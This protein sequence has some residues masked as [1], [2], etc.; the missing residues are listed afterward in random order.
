MSSYRATARATVRPDNAPPPRS[1]GGGFGG[2]GGGKGP[3][4][5]GRGYGRSG[6][7]PRWGRIIG[8]LAV[9]VVVLAG[10]ALLGAWAYA[11]SFDDDLKRTDA[12]AGLT[13]GRPRKTVD[14]ALNI[15]VLGTDSRDP[16]A[17]VDDNGQWRTDT[18]M[19]VHVPANHEKAYLISLPRDLYV[20][21]PKSPD[22][23]HGGRKAKLNAAFA[24]GG[25]P[26]M[27]QTVETYSGVRIDHV[28]LVDFWGFAA[29]TDAL[30]GVDLYIEK[31]I[32]SV[33]NGR[34]FKQG[35][36][37]LGGHEAL[38]YIRQRKQFPDGD[39]ARMRHQQQFLMALMKKA[40]DTG[41]L[42]SPSKLDAFLKAVT[43]AVT[44]DHDFSVVDMAL[45]FR[46]LRSDDLTFLTTPVKGTD[47]IN[48]ES[49]VVSDKEKALTLFQAINSDTM[50]E[51]AAKNKPT[52][53]PSN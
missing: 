48:G 8:V 18:I 46:S 30:G 27:V 19:L 40:T 52:P 49:V 25:V 37:H 16:E 36:M 12:F 17:K 28:A 9:V 53:K 50:T 42:T 7:R 24:W 3:G 35:M 4:R 41:T 1:A 11:K 26:L 51:W 32:T 47:T 20:E 43:K 15:L 39:F 10:A 34:V 44:V 6:A 13:D 38:D 33:H 31:T 22:G 2:D 29:V 14:G 21:V 5:G 45:Q 23:K